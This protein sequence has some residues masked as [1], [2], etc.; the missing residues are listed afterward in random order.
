MGEFIIDLAHHPQEVELRKRRFA[1]QFQEIK[2]SRIG[3]N[4][5]NDARREDQVIDMG[6]GS[7]LERETDPNEG[8]WREKEESI[9]KPKRRAK[10]CSSGKEIDSG[11]R[12]TIL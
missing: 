1:S 5:E 6:D 11:V 3:I 12:N 9:I 8:R 4:P 2:N 7:H 10:E